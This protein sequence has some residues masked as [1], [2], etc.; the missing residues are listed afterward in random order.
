M[1]EGLEENV[2][3]DVEEKERERDYGRV[4]GVEGGGGREGGDC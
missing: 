2:E 1:E 4:E 3:V